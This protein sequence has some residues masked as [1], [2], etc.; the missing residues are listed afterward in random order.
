MGGHCPVGTFPL[1][2][3][4]CMS[5][6]MGGANITVASP[7]TKEQLDEEAAHVAESIEKSESTVNERAAK[8]AK[9]EPAIERL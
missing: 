9:K 5:P 2:N 4:K 3:E 1:S 6:Q 7:M 8:M